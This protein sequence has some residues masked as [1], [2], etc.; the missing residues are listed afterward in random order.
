[1]SAVTGSDVLPGTTSRSDSSVVTVS[2]RVLISRAFLRVRLAAAAGT[3]LNGLW[4]TQSFLW[5]PS[6]TLPGTVRAGP[7]GGGLW[8]TT[9]GYRW[10]LLI[11]LSLPEAVTSLVTTSAQ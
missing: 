2:G 3:Y 8:I 7:D 5:S 4:V 1:M 10:V 9:R 11:L 6:V